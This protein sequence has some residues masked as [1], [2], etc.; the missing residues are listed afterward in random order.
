MRKSASL[1]LMIATITSTSALADDTESKLY[2]SCMAASKNPTTAEAACKCQAQKWA[3][4]KIQ[5]PK[6]PS[7]FLDIKK[8]YVDE[9]ITNWNSDIG[10]KSGA[11]LEGQNAEKVAITMNIGFACAKESGALH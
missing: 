1:F 6:D 7:K 2:A 3:S 4:G 10:V 5:S 11:H 8:E 9:L